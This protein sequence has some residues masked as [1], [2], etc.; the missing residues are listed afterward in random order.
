VNAPF[1]QFD[2]RARVTELLLH[3]EVP[4]HQRSVVLASGFLLYANPILLV[5]QQLVAAFQLHA[6]QGAAVILL[7]VI[8]TGSIPCSATRWYL[9]YSAADFEVFRP[10]GATRCTDRGEIWHGGLWSPP[11]CQ[12]SL[13]SVQRLGYTTPKTE[14][15]TEI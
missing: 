12:I 15:F 2:H 5:V 6:M 3:D 7:H 8:F 11:P 10:A 4:Y 9:S 1:V 13:P 14:I